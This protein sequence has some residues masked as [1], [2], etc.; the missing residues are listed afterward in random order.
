MF[1]QNESEEMLLDKP[2]SS[3]TNCFQPNGLTDVFMEPLLDQ[4]SSSFESAEF[5]FEFSDHNYRRVNFVIFAF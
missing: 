2:T 5:T 1:L 4:S 3:S